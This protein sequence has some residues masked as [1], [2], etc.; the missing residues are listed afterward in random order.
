MR[1]WCARSW[2]LSI[3]IGLRTVERAVSHLRRELAAE[4]LATV[5]F[6]T[7][8][9]RQLQI[10]FG[11]RR[12]E[13]EGERDKVFLFVATLGH[14]RRVYTAA[15]RNERQSAWLAGIEGAFR[16]F[17]GLPGEL[18][19]D[20]ARALVKHHDAATRKVEF[21]DRLHAFVRYWDVRPVACAPYRA[22]T[23]GK[24]E[25]GVGYVKHNAIAGRSFASWGALEALECA[26]A[27]GQAEGI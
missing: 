13:I 17:D 9:G 20:N 2:R 26:P 11:Q 10:D 15:F 25:R 4:A 18:L 8:P 6:E 21:T 16:H 3:V 5:R 24:D 12:I 14:S 7:P 23:K 19:L 27:G 1:T 22:R